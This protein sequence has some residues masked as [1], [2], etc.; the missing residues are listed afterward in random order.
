MIAVVPF[1]RE[2]AA[3]VVG[4]VLPIQRDEFGIPITLDAQPDLRDVEGFYRRGAGDFWVALD[5]DAVVGTIGLLDLGDGQAALRK[6]FVA[7]THRGAEHGIAARLLETLL[8]ACRARGLREVYLGTTAKFLAAHRFYEKQG[9]EEI[10]RADLPASFPVMTVDTKFYRRA[11]AEAPA[12]ANDVLFTTARL[13]VRRWRDGDL[14]ALVDVYGDAGAMRYVG[15][16][17][18]LA[19]ADCLRW[20]EVT[21]DN[22]RTRGYGMFAFEERG[23]AGAALGFGGLVH[24][25]GQVLPEVK[26]ALRRSHWGRGF[27]TE[28]VA[29]LLAYGAS[30]L[31]M[32]RIVATVAP[33]H[34]ASQRVLAKAG[35]R[36]GALRRNDD[37]S[38]TQLYDWRAEDAATAG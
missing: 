32:R 10:A 1:A 14:D 12:P 21:R 31:G 22:Y 8:D 35:L 28:A 37:G 6:M 25:G 9:F 4:L 20:L 26:Y 24:P 15:D 29:G 19:R 30:V 34:A 27:A 23:V 18:P 7:A 5:G 16:G 11:I 38:E 36:P 3:G 17:E 13:D 2:H 33:A